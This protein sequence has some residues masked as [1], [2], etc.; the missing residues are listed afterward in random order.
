M[1]VFHSLWASMKR[2][3]SAFNGL[4]AE[5]EEMTAEVQS[6]RLGVVNAEQ[7]EPK[8]IEATN[9]RKKVTTER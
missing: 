6:R 7:Q 2:L 4:A 3:T 9:G 1:N 8:Q 5:F